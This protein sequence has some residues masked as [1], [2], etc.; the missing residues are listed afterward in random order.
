MR[1]RYYNASITSEWDVILYGIPSKERIGHEVS[2]NFISFDIDNK[3][4]FYTDS[5]GLEM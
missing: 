5:N 4:T 1:V 2:V 3:N